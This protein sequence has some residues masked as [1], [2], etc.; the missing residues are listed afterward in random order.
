MLKLVSQLHKLIK[1]NI[2]KKGYEKR[3]EKLLVFC[4]KSLKKLEDKKLAKENEEEPIKIKKEVK[5]EES[6]I[7]TQSQFI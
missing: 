1:E 6:M 5:R 2:I 7:R 3:K 4:L